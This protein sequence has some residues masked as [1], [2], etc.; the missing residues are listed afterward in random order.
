MKGS[1]STPE[2]RG[3]GA[4]A[5]RSKSFVTLES[6]SSSASC[7]PT[8]ESV[9]AAQGPARLVLSPLG[10]EE[11]VSTNALRWLN[12]PESLYLDRLGV[13]ELGEDA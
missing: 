11:M 5:A 8:S 7:S 10:L 2:R 9:T 12:I 13:G 3:V 1:S 4:P 6:L